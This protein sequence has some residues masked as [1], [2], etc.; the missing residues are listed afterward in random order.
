M[1]HL[2]ERFRG[3]LG[4]AES[5]DGGS[6]DEKLDAEVQAELVNLGL[7]SPVTKE[8]SGALYHQQLA[9]QVVGYCNVWICVQLII[10]MCG[11]L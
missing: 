8:A 7:A 4:S 2:A 1:V 10:V 11:S 6:N 5:Q 9:R 3:T